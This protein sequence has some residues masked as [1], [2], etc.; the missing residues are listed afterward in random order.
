MSEIQ[1]HIR[2]PEILFRQFGGQ[3]EFQASA[4]MVV[5]G[6]LYPLEYRELTAE[7]A[8]A[9]AGQSQQTLRR[10]EEGDRVVSVSIPVRHVS[11]VLGVLTLEAG[12]VDEILGAQRRA[13][14]W[15]ADRHIP[16]GA[17]SPGGH[18]PHSAIQDRTET[19]LV[20]LRRT[21]YLVIMSSLDYEECVHK[22]LKLRVPEDQ[23]MELCQMVIECC[24]QERTYAKFYGHIGERLCKLHRRWSAL[25][26][27]S[28]RTYYD[29]IHRYETNRLRN[30]AR[31]FGALLA[32]DSISWACFEVVHMTEDDTTSS[33]RIF[34]KILMNE[35]QS[36]L[37][38]RTLD[39]L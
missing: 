38:L 37:G 9:L 4:Q 35:M 28:F 36:L 21:I 12:D 7:V 5:D 2:V 16:A 22:L 23:E 14:Y 3:L 10:N 30:I 27:Q 18:L 11:Q 34:I 15:D 32:T 29:T 39:A 33:S 19:N 17:G 8:N 31:F 25:Y 20:N 6:P 26:E 13:L 24:S 1:V